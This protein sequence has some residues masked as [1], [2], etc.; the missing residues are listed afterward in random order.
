[1][2][3]NIWENNS[4]IYLVSDYLRKISNPRQW[5]VY[6]LPTL[7]VCHISTGIELSNG[8]PCDKKHETFR[9]EEWAI[10]IEWWISLTRGRSTNDYANCLFTNMPWIL[11]L[12]IK[13]IYQDHNHYL[14]SIFK[15]DKD[16]FVVNIVSKHLFMFRLGIRK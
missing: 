1:M 8:L 11:F 4:N 12:W 15:S 7:S 16:A 3:L 6:C 2:F 5:L 9:L 10:N 14:L 13:T